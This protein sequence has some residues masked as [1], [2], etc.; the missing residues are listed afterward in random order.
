LSPAVRVVLLLSLVLKVGLAVALA[1]LEPRY[2]ETEYAEFGRAIREDGA[3]PRL[4]RAP[5]YQWFVAGGAALAGGRLVGVRVLQALLSVLASWL[6]YRIGRRLH[7]ERAGL[8][9]AA[10]LAFYPSQVAFSHLLW[11]ETV[12]GFFVV[13]ALDRLLAADAGGRWPQ[14]AAAGVALGLAALT[15][16]LGLVLLASSLAWLALGRG[17]R[18][19]RQAAVT[20]AL[21]AVVVAPWSLHASAR[22]GR[23]VLTDLNGAFNFWSGN[24]EYI[25]P[26]VQGIWALG[27][28]LENGLDP[29]FL[30]YYPDDAF[31]RE[32]PVRMA[33]AGVTDAQGPDGAA[34]YRREA[35]R[36]LREDPGGLLRRLPRKLAA[37]WAPD[38]FL[39]RH[40]LR[41]WYGPVSPAA[42]ATIVAVTWLAAAVPLVLGPAA[43]LA[44]RRSRFRALAL[45]WG[46]AYLLVHGIAYGHTRMHQPLVPLLL[47]AVAA[48]F[49]DRH[50]P[51]DVRRLVR[52]GVPAVALVLAGWVSVWPLLG[53]LYVHPGP[54][55]VGMA[56]FLALGKD[57]PLPGSARQ[58]W[59]LAGVEATRGDDAGAS[60]RLAAGRH[61]DRAWTY[62]L[63]ALM[64]PTKEEA[65]DLAARALERD[66]RL[67]AAQV[68]LRNLRAIAP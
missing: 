5:L 54:R 50:D 39:P 35:I 28:P 55:H 53:G 67:E 7:G 2:D 31:R 17:R 16:S 45:I 64:A 3:E 11:S 32:V 1:D 51:P 15:R 60:R 66:P 4:W 25:P 47:L 44:L 20:A 12:Y 34:W 6:V 52:R 46:G 13:L 22:A 8:W 37:F 24:N 62:Y 36:T 23:P 41:D 43:L 38:F 19:L 49:L 57:L 42:A 27:L 26:D 58:A 63:R 33:R 30:A 59:M 14:A 61:A 48:F 18:G 68:L 56:R 65:E 29:R 10:L 21:A 9:A 40:L